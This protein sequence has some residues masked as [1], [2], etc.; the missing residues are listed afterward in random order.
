MVQREEPK[1][2]SFKMA[3]KKMQNYG[4]K[5]EEFQRLLRF[6]TVGSKIFNANYFKIQFHHAQIILIPNRSAI[7]TKKIIFSIQFVM[8]NK[9]KLFISMNFYQFPERNT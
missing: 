8:N 4:Q 9:H 6:L 1:M 5:F 7:N 2:P 3:V